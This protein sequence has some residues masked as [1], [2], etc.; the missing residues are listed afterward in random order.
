MLT[1]QKI[2]K[3]YILPVNLKSYPLKKLLHFLKA[4]C[5]DRFSY[6]AFYFRSKA[7]SG[8]GPGCCNL[9]PSLS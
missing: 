5:V 4:E 9:L 3:V 2:F 8:P 1:I 6:L 7:A